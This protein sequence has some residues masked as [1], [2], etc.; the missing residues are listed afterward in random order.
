MTTLPYSD[1]KSAIPFETLLGMTLK[2]IRYSDDEDKIV[3][4]NEDGC[5]YHQLHIQDCCEGVH[6]ESIDGDLSNLIGFPILLAEEVHNSAWPEDRE[7]PN[8]NRRVSRGLFTNW[9]PFVEAS[10]FGGMGNQ[11]GITP[12][13]FLCTKS[14]QRS[15][16]IPMATCRE[17][18]R[19]LTNPKHARLG[20]GPVCATKGH[21][22][23]SAKATEYL[24]ADVITTPHC[25]LGMDVIL[26]RK[27]EPDGSYTIF[28]NVPRVIKRHCTSDTRAYE[29]GYLGSGP[30]ELALNIMASLFGV[31]DAQKN[32]G[33]QEFKAYFL[34]GMPEAGGTISARDIR[35]WLEAPRSSWE[36]D[37]GP[38]G[39]V[40]KSEV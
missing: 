1:Y 33:Y 6:I 30:A 37:S 36:V 14:H 29:W 22:K 25:G 16:E 19:E 13:K 9:R 11:M 32:A 28:A 34:A 38:G 15:K 3:F 5:E 18:G 12:K 39:Q 27:T 24:H 7:S 2:E 21:G 4:A 20:V 23:L 26:L 31:E 10:R 35:N 17:C 8:M 40:Q